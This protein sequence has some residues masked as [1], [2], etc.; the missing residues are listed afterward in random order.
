MNFKQNKTTDNYFS[1]DEENYEED[2]NENEEDN[3]EDIEEYE[4]DA[5]T[6]QILFD[7]AMN[8]FENEKNIKLVEQNEQPNIIKKKVLKQNKKQ[9]FSLTEFNKK[10]ET[11][12]IARKPKKFMSKRVGDKKIQLGMQNEP[13]IK[14]TFNPRNPPFNFVK[15]N[16]INIKLDILNLEDFPSL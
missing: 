14:R 5:E 2:E 6:R 9:I 8:S 16:E 11:D 12:M 15:S 10:V 13:V 3:G 7:H 1:D 4:L